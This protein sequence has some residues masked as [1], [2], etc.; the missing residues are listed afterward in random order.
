MSMEGI[1]REGDG[2]L[3]NV[4][5]KE[6]G[7]DFNCMLFARVFCLSCTIIYWDVN[8]CYHTLVFI[9]YA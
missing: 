4:F 8:I 9:L 1:Y 7:F 6:L 3:V 5:W 2:S